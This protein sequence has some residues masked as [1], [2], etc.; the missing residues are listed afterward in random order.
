MMAVVGC[1]NLLTFFVCFQEIEHREVFIAS[2]ILGNY[3]RLGMGPI[4]EGNPA[5]AH[6]SHGIQY[7]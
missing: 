6:A 7:Q 5:K 1:R 3:N 4:G 2:S